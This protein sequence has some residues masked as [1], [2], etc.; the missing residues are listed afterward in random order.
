MRD[1][2]LVGAGV[3]LGKMSLG[4][5]REGTKINGG[6]IEGAMRGVSN[7]REKRRTGGE[8]LLF[9]LECD[10]ATP[11]AFGIASVCFFNGRVHV[12]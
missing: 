10:A 11:F 6:G 9:E 3:L 4:D 7:Q 8:C 5:I 1:V 2:G 12:S